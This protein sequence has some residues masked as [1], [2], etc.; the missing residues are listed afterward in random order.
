MDC[1][2]NQILGEADYYPETSPFIEINGSQ[3]LF[4][5]NSKRHIHY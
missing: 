1:G 2:S 4:C 5:V 3:L